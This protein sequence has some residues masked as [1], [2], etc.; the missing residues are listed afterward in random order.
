MLT[1]SNRVEAFSG[2]EEV[3]VGGFA[4]PALAPSLVTWLAWPVS[5]LQSPWPTKQKVGTDTHKLTSDFVAPVSLMPK[6]TEQSNILVKYTNAV[7]LV[8]QHGK[9]DSQSEEGSRIHLQ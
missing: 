7:L 4:A 8:D 1:R 2:W 5:E 6:L 9:S 3:I